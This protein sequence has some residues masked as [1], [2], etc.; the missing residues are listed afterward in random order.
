MHA[1]AH[2]TCSIQAIELFNT[3]PEKATMVRLLPCLAVHKACD[4]SLTRSFVCFFV[5]FSLRCV[6]NKSNI[7]NHVWMICDYT[8]LRACLDIFTRICILII[9]MTLVFCLECRIPQLA[10]KPCCLPQLWAGMDAITYGSSQRICFRFVVQSRLY[11]VCITD[12]HSA[13]ALSWLS[14]TSGSKA[15][16]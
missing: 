10:L 6:C 1:T 4:D 14:R 9:R 11:K 5:F 8:W 15:D 12:G 13:M 7:S 3:C 16:S 2:K